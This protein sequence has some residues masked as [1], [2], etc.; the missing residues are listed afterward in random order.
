[1]CSVNKGDLPIKIWW[2]LRTADGERN[3][4]T[5]ESIVIAQTGNKLSVINIESVEAKHRGN[6]TCYAQNR[7]GTTQHSA[8]L[9]IFGKGCCSL[10]NNFSNISTRILQFVQCFKSFYHVSAA[11]NHAVH[12]RRRPRS[13]LRRGRCRHVHY[14]ERRPA[15]YHLVELLRRNGWISQESKH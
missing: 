10:V 15:D 7:A 6:Y 11:T 12:V 2:S 5:S 13:E 14:H 1:M 9:S 8:Y 3:L 4:S